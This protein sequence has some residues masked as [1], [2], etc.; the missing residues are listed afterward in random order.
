MDTMDL[1]NTKARLKM[2]ALAAVIGAVF[3]FFTMMAMSSSGRGPNKDPVGASTFPLLAIFV[4]VIETA[5]AHKII[6][7]KRR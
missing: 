7:K 3:T 1:R 6:S 2:L 5:L 4:F